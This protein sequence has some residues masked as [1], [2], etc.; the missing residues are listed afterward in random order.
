LEGIDEM[1]GFAQTGEIDEVEDNSRRQSKRDT[2]ADEIAG[3][4]TAEIRKETIDVM[5][6]SR[7]IQW[8]KRIERLVL[9]V[10]LGK[11]PFEQR[12]GFG[13]GSHAA[14]LAPRDLSCRSTA[15]ALQSVPNNRWHDGLNRCGYRLVHRGGFT[16]LLFCSSVE[17]HH[18][19]LARSEPYRA[20]LRGA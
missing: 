6:I 3:D 15:Q 13:A 12:L 16:R 18:L 4:L 20:N 8:D 11:T 19:N 5:T 17:H 9:H 14:E 1:E 7:R 10:K 2:G